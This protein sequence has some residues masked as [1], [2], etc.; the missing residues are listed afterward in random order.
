MS[1][2]PIE[3]VVVAAA[4]AAVAASS[5]WQAQIARHTA[6]QRLQWSLYCGVRARSLVV[7]AAASIDSRIS[8]S[9]SSRGAGLHLSVYRRAGGSAQFERAFPW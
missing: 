2:T 9:S 1:H 3:A 5:V 4:A 8:S 6:R 7:A